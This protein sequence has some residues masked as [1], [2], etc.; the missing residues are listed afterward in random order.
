LIDGRLPK[1]VSPAAVPGESST[2][3]VMSRA[4]GTRVA[5][6]PS[7]ITVPV[8]LAVK[9][10]IRRRPVTTMSPPTSASA[11]PAAAVAAMVNSLAL[12]SRVT[13]TRASLSVSKPGAVIVKV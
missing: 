1:A 12:L 8:V 6:S 2:T 4:T 3:E 9:S 13:G 11:V 5:S 10:T 7:S